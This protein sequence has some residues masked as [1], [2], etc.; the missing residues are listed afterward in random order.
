MRDEV[1]HKKLNWAGSSSAKG[2]YFSNGTMQQI[3][4]SKAG[5]DEDSYLKFYDMSGKELVIN[6]GKSYIA[7]TYAGKTSW[8]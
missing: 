3:H 8:E 2:Y 4:W 7:Y 6:R 5:G 1:G